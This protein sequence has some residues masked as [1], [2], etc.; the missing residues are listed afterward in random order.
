MYSFE[1]D[2]L[3]RCPDIIGDCLVLTPGVHMLSEGCKNAVRGCTGECQSSLNSFKQFSHECTKVNVQ[4]RSNI[5]L[6]PCLDDSEEQMI[7]RKPLA[8]WRRMTSKSSG[9]SKLSP[10]PCVSL[11]GDRATCMIML[12]KPCSGHTDD[13]ESKKKEHWGGRLPVVFWLVFES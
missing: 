8:S 4:S 12:H 1:G 10:M 2:C 7:C 11:D 13:A 6:L 5:F 9:K 3:Y